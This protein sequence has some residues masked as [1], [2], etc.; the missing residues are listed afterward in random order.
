[1]VV[2]SYRL[3]IPNGLIIGGLKQPPLLRAELSKLRFGQKLECRRVVAARVSMFRRVS[4]LTTT[5][6]ETGNPLLREGGVDAT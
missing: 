3:F 4:F 6:M 2:S 5:V 1:M